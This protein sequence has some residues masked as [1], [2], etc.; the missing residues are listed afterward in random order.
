[1]LVYTRIYAYIPACT[2]IYPYDFCTS[3]YQYISV[4]TSIYWYVPVCTYIYCYMYIPVCTGMYQFIW[5][6]TNRYWYILV[7]TSMYWYVLV[8]TSSIHIVFWCWG[9]GVCAAVRPPRHGLPR[10]KF[11]NHVLTSYTLLPR[12]PSEA[13]VSAHPMGKSK[14]LCLLNLCGIVGLCCQQHTPQPLST[15]KQCEY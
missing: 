1:M 5:V 10:P 14:P 6:H 9:A 8:Y 2:S 4:H 7:H 3:T 11:R 13:A 12:L 15:R